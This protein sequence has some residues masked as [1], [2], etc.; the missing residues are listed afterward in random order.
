MR[1]PKIKHPH[2][3]RYWGAAPYDE[4][5]YAE[6]SPP[7]SSFSASACISS[8]GE[9]ETIIYH[10]IIKEGTPATK[11][12]E[13]WESAQ[14]ERKSH[15]DKKYLSMEGELSSDNKR[16]IL[17]QLKGCVKHLFD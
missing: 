7:P 3:R 13:Q 8:S 14:R 10:R 15:Y 5:S 12:E 11:I 4:P 17:Q 2:S 9:N 1:T 6:D 16:P